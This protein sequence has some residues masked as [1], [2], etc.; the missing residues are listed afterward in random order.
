MSNIH[1]I[2][3]TASGGMVLLAGRLRGFA[4][5][6]FSVATMPL[7]SLFWPPASVVPVVLLLQLFVTLSGLRPALRLCDWGSV[8]G[9]LAGGGDVSARLPGASLA[10]AKC[11]ACDFSADSDRR[12]YSP[13]FGMTVP[14]RARSRQ[15]TGLRRCLMP[16]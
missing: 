10:A 12:G 4:G 16:V 9:L 5:F 13:L 2:A 8:R 1:W 15:H 11:S 6:G 14:A 3:L 7:L